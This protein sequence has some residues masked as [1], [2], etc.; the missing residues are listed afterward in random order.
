[1]RMTDKDTFK[2]LDANPKVETVIGPPAVL[3]CG[4]TPQEAML[5]KTLLKAVGAEDHNILLCTE[6]MIMQPVGQA[7]L[8]TK[9]LPPVP[10]DKLPRVMVMSGMSDE[11]IHGVLEGYSATRLRRPIF[12]T[13]T[14]RNL[15]YTV[16]ELL[17]ELL[18]EHRM[19]IQPK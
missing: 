13:A 6:Q 8:A 16:R 1:M 17:V 11:Q 9:Q 2:K 14:K 4:F 12:A 19:M 7:L 5:M 3:F 15:N 10:P 18:Q